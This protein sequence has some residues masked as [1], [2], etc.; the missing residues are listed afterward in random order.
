MNRNLNPNIMESNETFFSKKFNVFVLLLILGI[1]GI[2]I[3]LFSFPYDIPLGMDATTYFWYATDMSILGNFPNPE[4]SYL[5][6]VKIV[7]NGWPSFLSIIF[8][9]FNSNN[10]FEYMDL[11][12][13]STMMIS[14]LTIIPVYK[15]CSKFFN[16]NYAVLGAAIFVF[17]PRIILNS[18]AGTTEAAFIFICATS[19]ALFFS[20]NKK[21]IYCSFALASILALIRYE[22]LLLLLPL[23]II[24][25]VRFRHEKKLYIKY[26]IIV[27]I[28]LLI[29]IP[30]A[31][32][33]I[34]TTGEDGLISHII[35][36]P[37]YYQK[38]SELENTE[39][40]VYQNFIL[41]G[42]F[43]LIKFLGYVNFPVFILFAPLGAVLFLKNRDNKKYTIILFSILFLLP[44]FYAYSRNI[45][46]LRYLYVLYPIFCLFALFTIN[47]ILEKTSRKLVISLII[48]SGII[49]SSVLFIDYKIENYD[50]E[51]EAFLIAQH[52]DE[53]T[54][55]INGY[56]P[57][58]QYYDDFRPND[59]DTFP[60]LSS[61]INPRVK[62]LYVDS[63][64]SLEEFLN[65]GEERGLSHLVIDNKENRPSFLKDV[66]HDE[67]RFPF[68][69]N[70]FDS[71]D[72][73]FNY[74]VKVFKI[75]F[76]SYKKLI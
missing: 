66:F 26:G 53:I 33:R 32:I 35:K 45:L 37:T 64:D 52:I 46:E 14:V 31:Y 38:V 60:T 11:Q 71:N 54:Q 76:D 8:S 23:I 30:M 56:H 57:E 16:R 2:I 55:T 1:G 67:D 13:Y 69:E 41:V 7:N 51:R 44:A 17:E 42:S 25:F 68:L 24:F 65:Y 63:F 20:D 19:L 75:D 21:I 39:S 47:K 50:H 36:G 62:I 4:Q 9:L 3:R 40:D 72:M 34:E 61:S 74:H 22:G 15:L 12:R 29:L 28:I 48:I 27:G 73:G 59:L 10:I 5:E 49:I 18:L 70:I 6:H 43:N 58:D